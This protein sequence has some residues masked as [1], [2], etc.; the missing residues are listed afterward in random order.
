MRTIKFIFKFLW[1]DMIRYWRT[2]VYALSIKPGQILPETPTQ[3]NLYAKAMSATLD[4][5]TLIATH[6]REEQ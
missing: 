6:S 3:T 1:L 4:V 5:E 2:A